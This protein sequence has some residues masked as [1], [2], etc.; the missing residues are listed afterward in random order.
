MSRETSLNISKLFLIY[1]QSLI[2][3]LILAYVQ[4]EELLLIPH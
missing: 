2:D 4:T 3:E 1:L